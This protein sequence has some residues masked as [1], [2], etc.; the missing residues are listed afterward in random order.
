MQQASIG[1]IDSME[2][3]LRHPRASRS[4]ACPHP[5]DAQRIAAAR[6]AA[7]PCA[8]RLLLSLASIKEPAYPHAGIRDSRSSWMPLA[9]LGRLAVHG[10]DFSGCHLAFLP[11]PSAPVEFALPSQPVIVNYFTTGPKSQ[12][13]L[14]PRCV[15]SAILCNPSRCPSG[16]AAPTTPRPCRPGRTHPLGPTANHARPPRAASLHQ[17]P[18]SARPSTKNACPARRPGNPRMRRRTRPLPYTACRHSRTSP[19]ASRHV[20]THRAAPVGFGR[21]RSASAR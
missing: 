2:Q 12:W 15:L 5:T 18:A 16:A 1:K 3:P 7:Q 4:P 13:Y 20:L 8:A 21:F 14:L 9:L 19:S 6:R 17:L 11:P 10:R